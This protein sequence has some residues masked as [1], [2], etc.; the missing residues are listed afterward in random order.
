M[1]CTPAVALKITEHTWTV[2]ELI[3]EAAMDQLL[4]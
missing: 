3:D 4:P 1:G 2:E